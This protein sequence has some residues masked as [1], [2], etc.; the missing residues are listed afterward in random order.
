MKYKVGDKTLLG[1]IEKVNEGMSIPYM[2]HAG[3]Y[4][5]FAESEIDAIICKPK[6]NIDHLIEL[7]DK[8]KGADAVAFIDE[9]RQATSWLFW[10]HMLD[11]YSEPSRYPKL[12]SEELKAVR[13]LVDGGFKTI[14]NYNTW[15]ETSHSDD[16]WL[17]VKILPT[18][19]CLESSTW[20]TETPIDLKELFEAQEGV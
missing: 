14:R 9:C 3:D 5:W 4:R 8:K 11:E 1:E 19:H 18:A 17:D 6:R 15:V 20:I 2:I 16:L 12:T 13:W 10:I 7:I